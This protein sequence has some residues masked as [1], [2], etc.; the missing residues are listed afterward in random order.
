MTTISLVPD[1][2]WNVIQPLLPPQPPKAQGGRPRRPDRAVAGAIIFMLR[3]GLPGFPE[4]SHQ[5]GEV[6]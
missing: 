3:A 6:S 2:L 5:T 1:Q 4:R